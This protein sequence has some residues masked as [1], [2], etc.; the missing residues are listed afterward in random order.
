MS[1]YNGAFG[2]KNME[3][4]MTGDFTSGGKQQ[5]QAT[6]KARVDKSSKVV[7]HR[8]NVVPKWA[9]GAEG[10]EDEQEQEQ[11][12]EE[13][14]PKREG[15]KA[16]AAVERDVTSSSSSSSAPVDRRLALANRAKEGG[17]E[18]S[19]R[20]RRIHQ[21]EVIIE[22]Q[23]EVDEKERQVKEKEMQ[24]VDESVKDG[25]DTDKE[26][27]ELQARRARA[28]QLA[29]QREKEQE[30]AAKEQ[31]SGSE[32]ESGSGSGS[33]EYETDTDDEE[34]DGK[35]PVIKPVFLS[36]SQR[37]NRDQSRLRQEEA[38]ELREVQQKKDKKALSR[39]MVAGKFRGGSY[40]EGL[41]L[42]TVGV[43]FHV[44]YCIRQL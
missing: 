11:E 28:R 17:G 33:S 41:L 25:V 16:A 6:F 36:K 38:S 1:K 19:G 32:S 34:E 44:G 29:Q 40:I 4:L 42:Y 39:S 27:D 22:K 10:D 5:V 3:S 23:P 24:G 37:E 12:Q 30:E 21:A 43:L 20:R 14:A 13:A 15:V 26:K 8:A 31:E 9:E 18:T 2:V 7:R 35:A